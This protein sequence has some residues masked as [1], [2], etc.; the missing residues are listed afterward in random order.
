MGEWLIANPAK[1]VKSNW[2]RF[3]VNWLSRSQDKGGGMPSRRP[4]VDM[5]V[6]ENKKPD[7]SPAYWSRVKELRAQGIQGEALTA[8]MKEWEGDK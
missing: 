4:A 6:G 5:R 1:A 3:I 8:K 2:R 7:H